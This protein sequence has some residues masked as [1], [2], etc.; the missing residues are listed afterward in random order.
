MQATS[1]DGLHTLVGFL[2]LLKYNVLERGISESL[3]HVIQLA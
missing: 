3:C 2:G 1:S